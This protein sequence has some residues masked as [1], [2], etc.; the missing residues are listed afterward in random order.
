MLT[1]VSIERNMPPNLA[2]GPERGGRLVNEVTIERFG[3]ALAW[4]LDAAGYAPAVIEE[5]SWA[6]IRAWGAVEQYGEWPHAR[7]MVVK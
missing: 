4:A 6:A 2:S 3:I 5:I 1:S 7:L